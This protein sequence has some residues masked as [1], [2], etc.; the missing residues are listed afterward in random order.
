MG[1]KVLTIDMDRGTK[2]LDLFLGIKNI[3]RELYSLEDIIM[4]GFD[5]K[6]KY[7]VNHHTI[8][9]LWYI[10]ANH[11]PEDSIRVEEMS[12]AISALK[13]GFDYILIDS[14]AGIGKGLAYAV[15]PANAAI[16]VTNTDIASLRDADSVLF[17]VEKKYEVPV[18]VVVNKYNIPRVRNAYGLDKVMELLALDGVLGIIPYD[19]KIVES[20]NS[21]ELF[22][23][24]YP[25][26]K[27]TK[28]IE[29]IAMRIEGKDIP[30]KDIRRH[31]IRELFIRR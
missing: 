6:K 12:R 26:S 19:S 10:A 30:V 11:H 16:V 31:S 21:E 1:R 13:D 27:T 5:Q 24:K 15:A 22:I 17:E 28:E 18:N 29:N 3:T 7:A 8:D 9:N 2:N 20:E 4:Y 14:P 23:L 25:N